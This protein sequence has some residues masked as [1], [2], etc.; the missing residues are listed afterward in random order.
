MERKHWCEYEPEEIGYGNHKYGFGVYRFDLVTY[1]QL[2]FWLDIPESTDEEL[3]R[4]KE[5]LTN[6]GWEE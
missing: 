6:N 4:F 1:E 2:E 3:Q 5:Y